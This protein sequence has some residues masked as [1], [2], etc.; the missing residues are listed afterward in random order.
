M[1]NKYLK[2]FFKLPTTGNIKNQKIFI[3]EKCSSE[4]TD[5]HEYALCDES[6]TD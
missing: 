6:H 3:C 1:S 5:Y 4:F 2:E